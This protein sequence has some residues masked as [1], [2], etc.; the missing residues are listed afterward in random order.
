MSSPLR[1]RNEQQLLLC[2]SRRDL[3]GPSLERLRGLLAS[4]I[5]WQSLYRSASHH[6]LLPL[7]YRHLSSGPRELIPA[8]TLQNLSKEFDKNN[9]RNL[10]LV[11]ELLGVLRLIKSRSIEV[12]NIK[13]PLLAERVYGD[14]GLRT[15]ADIDLLI[16]KH[17]FHAVS[18]LLQN[19]GYVMEP[20]LNRGQMARHLEFHCEIQ[21]T[22][23]QNDCVI[24]LHW[25]LAPLSFSGAL[26]TSS[27]FSRKQQIS[28]AGQTVDVLSDEDLALYLCMHTAKHYWTRLEWLAA[29]A[30]L[31]SDETIDGGILLRR[32]NEIKARTMLLLAGLLV[33]QLFN[34]RLPAEL[35]SAIQSET[36]LATRAATIQ[37]RLFKEAVGALDPLETFRMNVLVMDRKREA[38]RVLIRSALTPTISDWEVFNLPKPFYAVYYLFR[39][40]RLACKYAVRSG[41]KMN[42]SPIVEKR[43]HS[44][45]QLTTG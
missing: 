32:A 3:D 20:S 6:G 36:R 42:R 14:L 11:R 45:E 35:Q 4:Q 10:L 25:A 39:P 40:I 24:D 30:E 12:L 33:Q 41:A 9:A 13:G 15:V 18:D 44:A 17:D 19:C 1:L 28:I 8:D 2:I 31:L 27:A 29:L 16:N 37:Q 34:V 21:F 43:E 7:L 23:R 26:D 22:N 38:M 5:D